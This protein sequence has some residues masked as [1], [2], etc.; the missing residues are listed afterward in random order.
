M[1]T[2]RRQMPSSTRHRVIVIGGG[3][4]GLSAAH[5]LQA[6]HEANHSDEAPEVL[7]LEARGRIGGRV[8]SEQLEDGTVVD[9]GASWVHEALPRNPI[10]ALAA[11]HPDW[12]GFVETKWTGPR[13]RCV[14]LGSDRVLSPAEVESTESLFNRTWSLFQQEQAKM[15]RLPGGV[16]EESDLSLWD[17]LQRLHSKK[18]QWTT[19]TEREQCLL[20][21]RWAQETEMDYAARLEDLSFTRWDDDADLDEPDCLWP[22]GFGVFPKWLA[23]GISVKLHT[24]VVEVVEQADGVAVHCAGADRE[25]WIERA[26]AVVVT[27]PLGVLKAGSVRFTPPL[28][29]E[30]QEAIQK[31]G[32]GLLNKVCLRF[33]ERVWPENTDVL[34]RV[35]G[36]MEQ[37]GDPVESP[38]FVCLPPACGS[39][40]LVAL[41]FASQAEKTETL[42]E[43][44][45]VDRCLE[46]LSE[47]LGTESM[48]L[49]TSLQEVRSTRWRAD[50][51]ACG[52][53]SFLPVGARPVHRDALGA[54]HGQRVFFAGEHVVR[55]YPAT[56]QGAHLSGRKAAREVVKILSKLR[57]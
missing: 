55:D 32:V 6:G 43:D 35:P 25:T 42:S 16:P 15:L 12:G 52:S 50:E 38:I 56:V 47:T 28:S 23:E 1:D 24:R 46:M 9:L 17:G 30:K 48:V 21:W 37:P 53:Y 49:R 13:C 4:A 29:E 19:L 11:K 27:L 2:D 8:W 36:R 40:V 18:F 14:E 44:T 22:K 39:P 10:V 31:I 54:M 57:R 33:D 45:L 51:Y 3:V 34:M 7:V 5:F 41:F 26:D 20:R